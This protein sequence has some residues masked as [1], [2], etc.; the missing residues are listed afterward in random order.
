MDG[1]L[2]FIEVSLVMLLATTFRVSFGFG[3]ALIAV[4]LLSL[5]LPVRVAAPLA[6]LASIL[7]AGAVILREWRHIHFKSVKKL[8]FGTVLGIPAGLFVLR[9]L[10]EGI[11]KALLGIFLFLFSVFSLFKPHLFTLKDE[12]FALPFGF[13]AGIAGGAYGM[14][15]PPLALYGAGRGWTPRQFRATLQAYFLPASLLGAVGYWF[16]GLLT[17]EV[18]KLFLSSLPALAAGILAGHFFGQAMDERRFTSFL[19]GGL[20][21]VAL[22]LCAQGLSPFIG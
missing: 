18:G 7:I 19:Y 10:P 20:A 9:F 3:E 5:L 12:R 22:V 8:L 11:T 17:A 13:F 14:N 16:S 1:L 15:G 21:G 6:V 2:L 4:P